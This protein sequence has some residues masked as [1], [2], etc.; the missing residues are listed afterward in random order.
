MMLM[1]PNRKW[2]MLLLLAG[3][4]CS[5]APPAREQGINEGLMYAKLEAAKHG[6]DVER[7]QIRYDPTNAIWSSFW[8]RVQDFPSAE[9]SGWND[10]IHTLY[11]YYFVETHV[12]ES[13]KS[14]WVFIDRTQPNKIAGVFEP[15][16]TNAFEQANVGQR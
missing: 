4:G 6:I 3:L 15:L 10:R 12:G 13:D 2:V 16:K 9:I 5:S 1:E 14:L 7:S 11:A 8:N